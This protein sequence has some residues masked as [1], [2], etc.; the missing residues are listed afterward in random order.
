MTNGFLDLTEK[1]YLVTGASSG[2]GRAISRVCYKLGCNLIIM[3]RNTEKLEETAE[4]MDEKRVRKI[5]LDLL[6]FDQIEKSIKEVINDIGK[7]DGFCHSAGYE[8]TLPFS[9]IKPSQYIELFSVN[10][11]AG[12]EL[13][14][15]LSKKK[16]CADSGSSFVFISSITGIVSRP[17]L[18]AYSASKGAIISAVRAMAIELAKKNIRVNSISPG[19]VMTPLIEDFI[20]KLDFEQ[21]EKRLSEYPLGLGKPDDIANLVAFLFSERSRWITGT[22]IV[23][24]GG[25]TAK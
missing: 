17:G 4:G 25:Y 3:G 13:A 12:F 18:A 5:S 11:V 19:T 16:Y 24:D 23:V 2:I 21:K 7:V 6:K 22:N 14:K 1:V 20:G 8:K 10:S 9:V 15:I